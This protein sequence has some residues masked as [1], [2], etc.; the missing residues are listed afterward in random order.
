MLTQFKRKLWLFK[1]AFFSDFFRFHHSQFGEDIVLNEL[2][3]KEFSNGFFVDV[4]CYHPKKYSNTYSLYKKGWRGIN[5]DMEE[6]KISLFILAR[7]E[8]FNVLSAVSDKQEEVTLYRYSKFGVGSTIDENYATSIN[9]KVFDKKIIQTKTLNQ[10]IEASPY[11]NRQIDVLSIDVEG[12]DFKVLNSLDID[13]YKPK[14]IV[15]EDHH[16]TINDILKTNIYQLLNTKGYILR[17]WTFYSL[18]FI[19]PKA[20]KAREYV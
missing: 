2:I 14:I 11:K 5:V 13:T 7:P 4:G 12:I 16:K 17:S 3:K 9:E 10:I 15:I 18:I 20:L 8:D 19:L 1:K 6:D